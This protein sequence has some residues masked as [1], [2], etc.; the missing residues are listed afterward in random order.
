MVLRCSINIQLKSTCWAFFKFST[1]M[2]STFFHTQTVGTAGEVELS[3]LPIWSRCR[4]STDNPCRQF[5]P[6]RKLPLCRTPG[7]ILCARGFAQFSHLI[8]TSGISGALRIDP[9]SN[10]NR[11]SESLPQCM[12]STGREMHPRNAVDSRGSMRMRLGL[13]W[14][15]SK[16]P[17]PSSTPQ[18]QFH[19]HL[20][21]R[22]YHVRI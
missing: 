9:R 10:R 16:K 12:T 17:Y 18:A 20:K 8:G 3:I 15:F 19:I 11:L 13:G 14:S 1:R 7:L 6:P 2:H 22:I 4:Q 5:Y 21:T